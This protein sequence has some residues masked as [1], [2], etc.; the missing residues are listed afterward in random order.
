MARVG[1]VG[2][3]AKADAKVSCKD[4]AGQVEPQCRRVSVGVGVDVG[5]GQ[6]ATGDEQ[7]ST[8]LNEMGSIVEEEPDKLLVPGLADPDRADL[9]QR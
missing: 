3:E 5:D 8:G 1:R 9:L 6:Q 2:R 4:D 7:E